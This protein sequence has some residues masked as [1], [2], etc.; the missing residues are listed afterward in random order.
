MKYIY[1]LSNLFILLGYFPISSTFGQLPKVSEP[2]F[3]TSKPVNINQH[4][5]NSNLNRNVNQGVQIQKYPMGA[6]ATDI[7]NQQNSRGPVYKPNS[8]PEENQ[9]ANTRYIQEQMRNDPMYQ[10]PNSSNG[11]SNPAFQKEKEMLDLLNEVTTIN[12]S[13][14]RKGRYETPEYKADLQNYHKA[15]NTLK[16]MLSGKRPISLADAYYTVEAAYGNLQMSY[17]EYK[18][19]IANSKAFITQWLIENGKNPKNPEAV[20]YGIQKF[21]GDNLQIS[22]N[23]T[24]NGGI[25]LPQAHKPFMYDYIDYRAEQDL[26]NYFLTKT[27]ATG[28][29]QCNT[30]PRV[31]IVIAE[32]MG[33]NVYLS[34]APQHSFIKYKNNNGTIQNYEPTIDWH[35]TDQDYSEGMPIMSAATKNKIYLDT[36]NKKQI[37]ASIMVDLAYNFMREHWLADGKLMNECI[38]YAMNFFHNKEGHDEALI[39]KSLLLASKLDK[40]LYENNITDLSNIEQIPEA[41]KAYNEYRQNEEKIMRLGIQYFPESEYNAMLEKH[42]NRGKLQ[43]AQNIDTKSKKSLFFNLQ[44]K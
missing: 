24:D 2:T 33:A 37:V 42:D 34:I 41:V 43:A 17:E 44:T 1:K 16:E 30:L 26:H 10:T 11:F 6:H 39:L 25:S 8:S 40:I 36:L 28:T 9:Q 5:T 27:L 7:I 3:P 35:M 19:N 29:G 21:M 22:N 14:K 18:K 13:V 23:R 38:D 4:Y 20:H 12:H 31:Y 15:L 32:A